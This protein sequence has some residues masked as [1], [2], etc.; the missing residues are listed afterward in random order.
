MKRIYFNNLEEYI[1]KEIYIEGFIDNIRD[2]DSQEIAPL[3]S[4]IA[5]HLTKN[6]RDITNEHLDWIYHNVA[7]RSAIKAGDDNSDAEL[8]ALAKQ[9]VN[10]NEVRFCPHGRPV[11]IELSKYELEKQFGRV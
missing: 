4:E 6:R 11:M 1:D 5:E 2:L 9:V 8:L 3:I 7:C 10:D